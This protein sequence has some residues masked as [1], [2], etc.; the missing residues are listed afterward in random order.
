ME[1]SVPD[2][3]MARST[4]IFDLLKSLPVEEDDQKGASS[5]PADVVRNFLG[6]SMLA[7]QC[8][9]FTLGDVGSDDEPHDGR[10]PL[11]PRRPTRSCASSSSKKRRGWRKHA[12]T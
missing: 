4:A 12:A 8:G 11:M 1:S 2:P 9:E 6:A 7:S 10:P 5:V 3:N